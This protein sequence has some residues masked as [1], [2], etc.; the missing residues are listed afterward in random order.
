MIIDMIFSDVF[1]DPILEQ[2]VVV[3]RGWVSL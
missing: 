1:D 2:G 3:L